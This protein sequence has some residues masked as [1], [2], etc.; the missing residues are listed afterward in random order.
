MFAASCFSLSR[1]EGARDPAHG[2]FEL[3]VRIGEVV[4]RQREHAHIA[5]D[6]TNQMRS[7]LS[8]SAPTLAAKLV[9]TYA[10]AS[11]GSS[12]A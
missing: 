6:K 2:N 8:L 7:T 11:N 1:G 4:S 12:P 5:A 3:V 9:R 10:T